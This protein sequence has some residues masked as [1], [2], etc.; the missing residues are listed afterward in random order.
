MKG[1]Y[2]IPLV[3]GS[4]TVI[5]LAISACLVWVS[6]RLARRE[7]AGHTAPEPER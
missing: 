4:A 3:F 6:R 1:D 2:I 7:A 5:L